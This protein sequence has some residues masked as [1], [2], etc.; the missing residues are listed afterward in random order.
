LGTLYV[1]RAPVSNAL[2]IR[3]VVVPPTGV[4]LS[5]T[6]A[7]QSGLS[8]SPDGHQLAFV[9][10]QGGSSLLWI[11]SFDAFDSRPLGGTEGADLP[12]WSP[13]SKTLGFFANSA[14]KTLDVA[15]GSIRSLC[16][17]PNGVGGGAWNADGTIVFGS[18]TG[19]GGLFI[20]SANGGQP[21]ALTHPDA[22]HGD[23]IHRLPVFLPDG[24]HVLYSAGFGS[25]GAIWLTALDSKDAT[26]L[27]AADTQAQYVEPG[28]LL[29]VRQGTLVTQRFDWRAARLAGESA[30]LAEQ[31]L[32]GDSFSAFTASASGM[33]AYRIG[34][35]APTTQ[36]AWVDR[37]GRKVGAVEPPGRYRNPALSPDGKRAAVEVVDPVTHTA[38]VWM[39]DLGRGVASQFT[40]DAGNDMYP[41]W[42]PDG[43]WIVFGSDRR[44]IFNLY[45][46]QS[47]AVGT[48]EPVL[49][50][51]TE[52]VPLAWTPDGSAIVARVRAQ[53][54]LQMEFGILPLAGDRTPQVFERRNF[55]VGGAQVSPD[56]RWVA[57]NSRESG[58]FEI[59]VQSFPVPGRG[60]WQI[61]KDGGGHSRWRRDG[62]ELF[63]YALDGRLMGVPITNGPSLEIGAAV[64]LFEPHLLGGPVPQLSNRQQWDVAPDGRFLTNVPVEDST[65]STINVVANWTALLKK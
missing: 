33:L 46:K 54:S 14:L 22:A 61:S 59:Y 21:T 49:K 39:I 63:F 23:S 5:A 44:G 65:A 2:P 57:Y 45:R 4:S 32:R 51:A 43:N 13:D 6:G 56:G 12:F 15:V 25:S 62:R 11:R 19:G 3:F 36:L 24:R 58:R 7:S 37:S 9:A 41:I 48:E 60:K 31:V 27:T 10:T 52:M 40:F 50:S 17:V 42:S 47:N 34:T 35:D 26:R 38:D 29:F 64:A 18:A 28:Y 55:S 16:R 20:V 30:P 1:R 53:G 8:V